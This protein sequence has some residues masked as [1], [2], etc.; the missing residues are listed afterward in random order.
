MLEDNFL[1]VSGN[2]AAFNDFVSNAEV[3]N[4]SSIDYSDILSQIN[5]GVQNIDLSF[6]SLNE[7]EIFSDLNITL[8][9]IDSGLQYLSSLVIVIIIIVLLNYVYKFFK[10]FF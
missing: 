9:H 6:A 2:N 3:Y 5:S 4:Y 10:M 7:L 8:N 1:S